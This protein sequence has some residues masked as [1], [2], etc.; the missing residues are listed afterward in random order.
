MISGFYVSSLLIFIG[1][2]VLGVI[3]SNAG[4]QG[5]LSHLTCCRYMTL[6]VNRLQVSKLTADIINAVSIV[7]TVLCFLSIVYQQILADV[8]NLATRYRLPLGGG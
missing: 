6:H 2:A 3:F 8:F 7:V 4:I 1:N 5:F